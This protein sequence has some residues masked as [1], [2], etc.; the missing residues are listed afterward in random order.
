ML[1]MGLRRWRRRVILRL[2]DL[3][4]VWIIK[5][6]R[7]RPRSSTLVWGEGP[8]VIGGSPALSSRVL[9]RLPARLSLLRV[10]FFRLFFRCH[11][12]LSHILV[13]GRRDQATLRKNKCQ[14]IP[15][16]PI[17]IARTAGACPPTSPE[18]RPGTPKVSNTISDTLHSQQRVCVD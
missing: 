16:A 7:V 1:R 10:F 2:A 15:A 5:V 17:R 6:H 8:Y 12:I 11:F 9:V 13:H 18:R 14:K 3:G 4:V